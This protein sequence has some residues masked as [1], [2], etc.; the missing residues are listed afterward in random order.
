MVEAREA[1]P[2]EQQ[3]AAQ[4]SQLVTEHG[5]TSISN[6]VVAKIAGTAAREIS[7]VHE[8]VGTGAGGTIAGLA[9]RVTGGPSAT[10]GVSVEVGEREAAIDLSMTVDYGVS[11]PQLADAVRRNVMDRVQATCG[12]A[13]KEVNIDVT[14]IY[15]PEEQA[16]EQ[17]RV[18]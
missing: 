4:A 16:S 18:E 7:G 14:D 2:R 13:V 8:L 6:Q 10:Q 9:Q 15:L 3:G 1:R 17:R 5:K 12:L 11:I